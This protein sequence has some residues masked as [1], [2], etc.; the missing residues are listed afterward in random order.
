MAYQPFN[1]KSSL[2]IYIR[3]MVCKHESSKLN[4]SKFINNSIKHQSFV[5]TQFYDQTV[6]FSIGQILKGSKYCYVTL[7]SFICL[8]KLKWLNDSISNNSL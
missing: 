1:A 2:F 8:H 5:Y 6:L 4:S 7:T 3:Y